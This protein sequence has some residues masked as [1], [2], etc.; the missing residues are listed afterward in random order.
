[1]LGDL[2][3]YTTTKLEVALCVI[4]SV[5]RT[6]LIS[7]VTPPPP[8]PTNGLAVLLVPVLLGLLHPEEHLPIVLEVEEE[9]AAGGAL[10]DKLH[11][12]VTREQDVVLQRRRTT[13]QVLKSWGVQI[14]Y[15]SHGVFKL[16]KVYAEV[17]YYY[18]YYIMYPTTEWVLVHMICIQR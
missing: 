2:P 13:A 15:V 11:V 8:H 9:H 1:M 16:Y 4:M 17:L 3:A 14:M 18:Y 6:V 12:C 10:G 7:E 5:V